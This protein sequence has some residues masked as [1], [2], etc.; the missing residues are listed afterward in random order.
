MT[1][2]VDANVF[3]RYIANDHKEHSAGAQAFFRQVAAGETS[4]TTSESV[5]AEIVYVLQSPRQY[6]LPR[7]RIRELLYPLLILRGMDIPDL[8][9]YLEALD[10]YARFDIDFED[11][12][13]VAHV[14][15]RRL[16]G[17]VSFDR[18]FDR[19]PNIERVEPVI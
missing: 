12:L 17:V 1:L 9:T 15:R 19:L 4:A 16:D 2:F 13:S 7:A 5:V 10:L 8:P 6:G 18:D 11:A 3:L 14:R